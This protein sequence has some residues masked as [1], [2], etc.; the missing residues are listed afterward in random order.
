MIDKPYNLVVFIGRFQPPTNAHIEIIEHALQYGEQVLILAG[1]SSQPRTIKNPWTIQERADMIV[2]NFSDDK[3]RLLIRGLE[4]R[5]YNDQLWVRD[6]QQIVNETIEPTANI[7][8]IGHDK[9]DS[10][11]YLQM[12]PQWTPLEMENIDDLNATD[13]REIYF[14]PLYT[15]HEGC[16]FDRNVKDKL[17]KGT[18]N[19]LSKFKHSG[20]YATLVEEF[21]FVQKY[22]DLWKQAPY[23]VIFSTT[24]AVVV[25]SGHVLMVRRKMAPGKNLWALVGGFVK[26]NEYLIDAVIRELREK[27]KLKVPVPV[28]KGSINKQKVYDAPERSL[29]G[30]T[31]TH[32]YLIELP[33]GPLSKVKG[34]N[35]T[36]RA[37]WIPINEIENMKDQIFEDHYF[38]ISD[39]LGEL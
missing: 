12:F 2:D 6:V 37:Q 22:K 5:L 14:N 16:V 25:Q 32:A 30:R 27:A 23:P 31:I 11:Y 17:P 38:I 21:E 20:D 7:A 26:Q 19:F 3:H 8:I 9:D 29:R 1:S 34:G 4:D 28:L 35:S 15:L 39:L 13:I 36:S 24:D 18:S 10:S 33:A